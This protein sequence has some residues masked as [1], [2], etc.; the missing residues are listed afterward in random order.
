MANIKRRLS[1][2]TIAK[3]KPPATGRLEVADEIVPGL[4]LRITPHGVRSF[5]VV[6]KV[7]GEG[8]YTKTGRPKVGC[9][10]RMTLG[11]HPFVGVKEAREKARALLEIVSEGRDPRPER[12]EA[13]RAR[14]DNTV[15]EVA[16]R[17]IEQDAKKTVA[18]W[19]RIERTLEMHVLPTIGD[20]PIRDI[21]RADVHELLDGLVEENKAGAAAGVLKHTRRLFEFALDR[22]LVDRNPAR[23][24]KRNDLKT[25][26]DA[27]RSLAD[28]ELR[29]VWQAAGDEGYPFGPWVRL[30]MITGQRRAEWATAKRGEIDNE[31]RLLEIPAEKYK[32]NRDHTVPLVGPAWKIVEGL[33]IWNGGDYLFTTTGGR[34]PIGGFSGFKKRLDKLAPTAPWSFHDLRATCESRMAALGIV[35]EHRD[36][37][38]GH[39]RPGL[40]KIYNKFD[41]SDEKV[42]ALRAYAAHLMEV[43]GQ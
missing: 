9:Q 13:H 40:Q 17:F 1:D 7:P 30:L 27:R 18:S 8:G 19:R 31:K 32:G 28:E 4:V 22:E 16:K 12:I 38:L 24:L 5:S 21:G 2:L 39:A 11:R 10:H 36:A 20:R 34:A 14:R 33:P 37:V 25:N 15:S 35:Q 42:E 41:Y 3:L 26:G 6:F 43:V 23:G 29:A